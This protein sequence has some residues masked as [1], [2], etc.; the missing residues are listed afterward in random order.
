MRSLINVCVVL[1]SSAVMATAQ[2]TSCPDVGVERTVTAVDAARQALLHLPIGNGMDTNVSIEARSAIV[3]MKTSLNDLMSAY[4]QTCV[5]ASAAPDP[6]KIEKDLS[7]LAHAFRMPT[8]VTRNE[9]LPKDFGRY[10][11][12]LWFEARATKDARRLVSITARFAI[13]CGTDTMLLV[14]SPSGGSWKEVLR[15]E[16]PPYNTVAGAFESFQYGISPADASGRWYA[17]ATKID[18]WC[19]STWS[20]IRFVVMRPAPGAPT[21]LLSRSDS[22]WWGGDDIGELVVNRSEFDLRFHSYD[23]DAD[24]HDRLYIRHYQVTDDR[25]TRVQPVAAS[26]RDFVEEWIVS[27]WTE[28]SQWSSPQRLDELRRMH[29]QLQPLDVGGF[30]FE[31]ARRCSGLS[32]GYEF[33]LSHGAERKYYLKVTGRSAFAMVGASQKPDPSCRGPNILDEATQ[34]R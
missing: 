5:P 17:V 24:L 22:I 11:F 31:A 20:T 10:G 33:E 30:S 1:V 23:I 29:E 15:W 2:A 14:F 16:S 27:P 3:Q 25:V 26:P 19:S 21:I 8:G 6:E 13:K 34:N 32:D 12:E 4:M 9:D 7:S 18:P 28:A